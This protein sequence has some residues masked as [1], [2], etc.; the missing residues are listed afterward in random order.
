MTA[1]A[2]KGMVG[3]RGQRQPAQHGKGRHR[4]E[5]LRRAADGARPKE[6]GRHVKRQNQERHQQP[7]AFQ[8]HGQRRTKRAKRRERGRPD[9]ERRDQRQIGLP[10]R[11]S[12]ARQAAERLPP[13]AGPSSTNGRSPW[14]GR[15]PRRAGARR[16]APQASH[17]PNRAER[18]GRATADSSEARRSRG[19][20]GRSVARSRC[21]GPHRWA[22][23]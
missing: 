10:A 12:T 1:P 18:S 16:P 17:P 9:Q 14:P 22:P 3:E 15:A 21:P 13:A 7:A 11:G 20:P 19:C 6:Q 5:P 23:A 2:A 4:V 8:P